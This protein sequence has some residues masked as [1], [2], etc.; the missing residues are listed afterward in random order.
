VADALAARLWGAAQAA[1]I[2]AQARIETVE[3]KR[4]GLDIGL[5]LAF[6]FL[7][8]G[9]EVGHRCQQLIESIGDDLLR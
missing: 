9:I 2:D 7:G 1:R 8:H 5:S 4:V 6:G 3:A